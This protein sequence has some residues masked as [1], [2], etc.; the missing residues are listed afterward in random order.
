MDTIG[1]FF[2]IS[3]VFSPFAEAIAFLITYD[4]Y[5]KHISKKQALRHGL[6]MAFFTFIIFV[7]LGIIAGLIFRKGI[8]K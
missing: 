6:E 7:I 2:F 1:L 5:V 3:L 4:E 8:Q